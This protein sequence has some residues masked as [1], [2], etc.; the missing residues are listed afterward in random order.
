MKIIFSPTKSMDLSNSESIPIKT[1]FPINTQFILEVLKKLS[2]DELVKL[3]KIKGKTLNHVID[4]YNNFDV[5][6]SKNAIY[7]YNGISFKQIELNNYNKEQVKYLKTHLIILSALYGAI[8]PFDLICEY[9]L[10]MNMKI[11][12]DQNLYKF[13]KVKIDN[14]FQKE[15]FILNLASK[16]FSKLINKPMITIDFKEKKNGTYKSIS[17]YSKKGRGMMLN[18]L[19]KN[20]ITSIELIKQF[21]LDNYKFNVELSDEFNLIFTR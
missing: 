2:P 7:S 4:I 15:D 1:N 21:N 16:E 3:M 10:D 18:Y 14:Y 19:I 20:K 12:K 11:F 5:A 17:S 9:R 6:P 13:W 8:E